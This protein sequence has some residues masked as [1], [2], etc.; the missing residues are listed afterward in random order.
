MESVGGRGMLEVYARLVLRFA[1]ASSCGTTSG[2]SE[3]FLGLLSGVVDDGFSGW[4]WASARVDKVSI[5]FSHWLGS[6]KARI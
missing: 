6:D 5:C 3:E 4:C 1:G 2:A